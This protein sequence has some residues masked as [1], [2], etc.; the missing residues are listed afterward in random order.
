VRQLLSPCRFAVIRRRSMLICQR[1]RFMLLHSF[2]AILPREA[3][4]EM[5]MRMY[6]KN[7]SGSAASHEAV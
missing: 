7:Q 3:R 2:F 4:A 6:D 5:S 1:Y